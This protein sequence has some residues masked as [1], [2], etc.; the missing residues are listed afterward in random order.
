MRAAVAMAVVVLLL[1][2]VL[3]FTSSSAAP[4]TALLA[5]AGTSISVAATGDYGYQPDT[6]EMVPT[7]TTIT[8]TFTDDSVLAHTFTIIGREGWVVPSSYT[9]TQIDNLAY[10]HSPSAL[11]NVNVSGS[12][13]QNISSFTSPGPGW[14]EFLCAVSG[15]F[16][17]GMYG[18]IAFGEN[19]PSNL[20]P[21]SSRTGLG[22]SLSFSAIDAAVIAVVVLMLLVGY[23]VWRRRRMA[24]EMMIARS[25]HSARS[26]EA[27]TSPGQAR[28]E[29]RPK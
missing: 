20:T 12:G 23:L 18:F 7:N 19:L 10:G 13:D 9:Y 3:A 4:T 27:P 5:A 21:P 6:I 29:E 1:T 25:A 26:K 24:R 11:F 8:V 14:Y 15:H 16:Q 2:G 22:G 17:N 28:D